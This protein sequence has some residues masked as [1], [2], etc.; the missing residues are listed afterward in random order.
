MSSLINMKY[1]D[2]IPLNTINRI[3]SILADLNILTVETGWQNSAQGFYSVNLE[4][5]N[6][7][8]KSNGKGTTK[9]YALASAYGELIERLQNQAHFRLSMDF[10]KEDFEYMGFFYTPDEKCMS[11]DELLESDEDWIQT[12]F[13]NIKAKIEKKELLNKWTG[14]SYEDIPCDFI[15]IPY[16]NIS[17]NKLSHIPI[18]MLSKMYMS[19]GMCAGNTAHEALVQGICEIIERYVNK[20][21]IVKK[22][23]PPTIPRTY[24]KNYPRIE[25]MIGAIESNGNYKVILKDCSLDQGYPVV[26]AIFINKDEQS[27]FIKLGAH[28]IFEIAAERSLTELLQGQNIKKMMGVKEFSYKSNVDDKHH[29]LINILVNG[30][31]IYPIELFSNKFSYEFREFEDIKVL[32]NAEMLN[33]L[34]EFLHNK[35]F[36]IFIRDVSYLD[37]PAFHVIVPGLSEIEKINDIKAITGYTSYN[38]VKKSIRNLKTCSIESINEIFDF[39]QSQRYSKAASVSQF[40]N[41]KTK[42]AFPWYY[43]SIDLFIGA[44]HY[45]LGHLKESYDVFDDFVNHLK[46]MP[47][48]NKIEVIFYK[49][50]RD[51]IGAAI[52]GL[53]Q[54][55]TIDI[56]KQFY[57]INI[58]NGVINDIGN[59]ET[60]LTRYGE[61]K[62]WSCNECHLKNHCLNHLTEGLYKTLKERYASASIEQKNLENIFHF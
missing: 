22:I 40:L 43:T 2:D 9:E 36:N 54:A 55:E 1:K 62:C 18:K 29:N 41:L 14:I 8:I 59:P 11:I 47:Y 39:F 13:T 28:P 52:D 31:G 50:V 17:N 12:Q 26:G 16:L 48:K 21:I 58:I 7:N 23:S 27:Y 51:Y 49:C 6:T 60:I 45:H 34:V 30:S 19:N 3:R 53:N 61:L 46:L 25:S 44:L 57:P 10:S 42:N 32:H 38:K 35:D 20:E 56:L 15:A 33:Y 37:F 4:I 24:I 5:E